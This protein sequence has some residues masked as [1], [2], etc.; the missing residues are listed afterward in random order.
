MGN[1]C[2]NE[3]IDCFNKNKINSLAAEKFE[4]RYQFIRTLIYC[5]TGKYS[6]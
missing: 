2:S 3:A 4:D 6:I 1:S 5:K